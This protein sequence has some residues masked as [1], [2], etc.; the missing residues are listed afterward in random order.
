MA[1]PASGIHHLLFVQAAVHHHSHALDSERSLGDGRRQYH[2]SL[3]LRTGRDGR[4]LLSIGKHPVKRADVR[5]AEGPAQQLLAAPDLGLTGEE[6]QD[7]ALVGL[8]RLPHRMGHQ[9]GHIG[10]ISLLPGPANGH[11]KHLS[12][13]LNHL[14]VQGFFQALGVDGGRHQD[15]LEILPQQ[16]LCL[17]GKG[18]GFIRSQAALV[19]LVKNNGAHTF[20]G[21]IFYEH[22]RQDALGEHL[23]ARARADFTLKADSV[24]NGAAHRLSQQPRH[25]LGHL[26][27]G[28][29]PWL[30]HQD[31][32]LNGWEQGEGEYRGFARTRRRGNNEPALAL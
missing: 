27:G 10:G 3:A 28:H 29:P 18:Q 4:L 30:Q 8:V 16:R 31:L 22:A 1:E 21:R 26:P 6:G 7:I 23:D 19:E 11:R 5:I 24:S 25:P 15:N 2:F 13:A 20:Q 12:L 14:R 32:A 9:L 17:P